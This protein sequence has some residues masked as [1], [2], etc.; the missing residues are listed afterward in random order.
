MEDN[1]NGGVEIDDALFIK[2][3]K[4]LLKIRFKDIYLISSDHVYLNIHSVNNK[5][6]QI[7]MS[8]ASMQELLPD[9]FFKANRGSLVN[10]NYLE[11]IFSQYIIVN[12]VEV[13]IPKTYRQQLVQ[14]IK[15]A[16]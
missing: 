3:D 6:K 12:K 7:R 5:P 4:G 13:Q 14:L 15:I 2:K 9:F 16:K 1:K 8:V 10:L 11:Q